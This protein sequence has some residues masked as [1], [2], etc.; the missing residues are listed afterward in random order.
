[1]QAIDVW[2]VYLV[3]VIAIIKYQ[4]KFLYLSRRI[5]IVSPVCLE[6][7]DFGMP[8]CDTELLMMSSVFYPETIPGELAVDRHW[9]CE[10]MIFLQH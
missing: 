9:R 3:S 2:N 6:G 1:M 4:L 5:K 10:V 7:N 8:R